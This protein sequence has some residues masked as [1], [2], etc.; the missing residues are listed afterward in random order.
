[1]KNILII[2]IAGMMYAGQVNS[3]VINKE[4]LS[5]RQTGYDDKY[6]T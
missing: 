4:P 1:M 5:I 2:L 6:K 3:Q